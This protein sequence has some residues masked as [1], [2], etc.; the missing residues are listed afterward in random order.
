[1][2]DRKT[3]CWNCSCAYA[4]DDKKCPKCGVTNSNHDMDTAINEKAEFEYI[5]LQ[6]ENK[7]LREE[8][9]DLRIRLSEAEIK[10]LP[11]DTA[12]KD[13]SIVLVNDTTSGYTPSWVAAGWLSGDEWSG[14]TY[15]NMDMADN[16]P[17]GP[18]PTHW[19]PIPE[20]PKD[21]NIK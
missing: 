15:D 5:D 17:L 21:G 18:C 16:N 6:K 19:I 13:G 11:I 10:W 3:L 8:N 1:M 9:E 12:S 2:T 20:L 4:V 14:W 7:R